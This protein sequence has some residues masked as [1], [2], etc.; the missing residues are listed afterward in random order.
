MSLKMP[1][2]P[3]REFFSEDVAIDSWKNI[4]PFFENLLNREI[5]S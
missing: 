1:A 3:K 4:E 5:N 2:K